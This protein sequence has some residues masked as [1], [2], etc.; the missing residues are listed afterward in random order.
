MNKQYYLFI[1]FASSVFP[2]LMEAM[3]V[4]HLVSVGFYY[5]VQELQVSDK[6]VS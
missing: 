1:F 2:A 5:M 4:F 3:M 6:V